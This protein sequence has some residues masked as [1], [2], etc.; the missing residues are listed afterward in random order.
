MRTPLCIIALLLLFVPQP[1]LALEQKQEGEKTRIYIWRD[2]HGVL[3]MKDTRPEHLTPD[4]SRMEQRDEFLKRHPKGAEIEGQE[5]PGQDAEGLERDQTGLPRDPALDAMARPGQEGFVFSD[6]AGW[7]SPRGLYG[8]IALALAMAAA[9][10]LALSWVLHRLGRKFGVGAFWEYLIPVYNVA[11]L[12]RCAGLT[13]WY[14]L[15]L[16]VP[17]FNIFVTFLIWGKIAERL[18]KN[19]VLWGLLCTLLGLPVLILA[20][21]ASKPVA[22]KK[23]AE[24]D[25]HIAI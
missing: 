9:L 7:P 14:A 22:P 1:C 11:L 15:F 16:L 10:Y 8:G 24:F 17:V 13:P 23:S 19:M 20:L 18:G 21:D 4:Q 2:E 25:E 3:H 5:L 6:G 12:C